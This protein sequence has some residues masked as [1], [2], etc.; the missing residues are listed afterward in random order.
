[1][2]IKIKMYCL[3]INEFIEN[4]KKNLDKQKKDLL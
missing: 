1:M 3:L 2:E 4:K